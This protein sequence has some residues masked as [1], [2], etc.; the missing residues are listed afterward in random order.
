MENLV[1]NFRYALRRL[2]KSPIHTVTVL[3]C[4]TLGIGAN[5][6]IFSVVNSLLLQPLPVE[7]V[8]RLVFALDVR[9]EDDPFEASIFDYLEFQKESEVFSVTGLAQRTSFDLL[10]EGDPIRLEGALV[11]SD[12]FTTLGLRSGQGR[13]FSEGEYQPDGPRVALIG[14]GLWM[15][16]FGGDESALGRSVRLDGGLVTIVGVLPQ[17][18]DLPNTTEIWLPYQ[19]NYE[20]L[21]LS[22]KNAHDYF[23][24]ARL[25]EGQS[26][27]SANASASGVAERLAKAYPD[28]RGGWNTRLITLR[29]QLMGDI[30]GEVRPMLRV[31]LF[32]VSFLLLIACANVASLLLVRSL[33]RSQEIA[34]RLALGATRRD[35]VAQMLTESVFLSLLG[36]ALGLLLAYL[37]T[38]LLMSLNPISAQSLKSFFYQVPL[39]GRVLFYNLLISLVTGVLFGLAPALRAGRRDLVLELKEGAKGSGSS[40]KGRRWLD[41]LVVAEIAVAA[42]LLVGAGL[43]VGSFQQ[44]QSV[45]LGFEPTN[46][47]AVDL[48]LTQEKY[49]D[50]ETR[51]AFVRRLTEEVAPLPGVLSVGVTTNTP[52]A[53]VPWDASYTVEGA[54]PPEENQAPSSS[55]RVVTPGY[56]ETMGMRLVRGRLLGEQDRADSVSAMVVTEAFAREAFGSTQEAIGKRVRLGS[57]PVPDFEPFEVVG[58]L[59]DV[60]E[61]RFN[62]RLDRPAWY[63]SYY[64]FASSLPVSLVVRT[65]GDPDRLV[66]TIRQAVQAL[67]PT[68]PI[69]HIGTMNEA[70]SRLL[71]PPR[72][73][74]ILVGLFATLGLL[75]AAIGL[76]G[77]M[78]YSVN[79][80]LPELGIRLA[81]GAERRDLMGLVL[82]RGLKLTLVGLGIGLLASLVLSRWLSSLLFEIGTTDV[83]TFVGI[84]LVLL[85]TA[86]LATFLPARRSTRIDPVRVLRVE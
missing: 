80:R 48:Y 5:T 28:L 23:L 21:S 55:H 64:Q 2:I 50:P 63:I 76:Y 56:L 32:V 22:A 83:K 9:E 37:L 6:A 85:A 40:R 72:F 39:D 29:Q 45:D 13:L 33:E 73:A 86:L 1:S 81:M 11:S 41:A 31:V 61:D 26:F 69:A 25:R 36:G 78:T 44:M 49:Q 57:P 60:K 67:D 53:Q 58:V 38:P 34:L 66:P 17:G 14:H 79:Q 30:L 71:N 54:P 35:L 46:V 10:G 77:V 18:F 3:A 65:S 51:N 7:D 16:Q 82:G 62:F 43:M 19:V 52:L 15:R 8:D 12:Y 24:I 75:L 20:A 47:I 68:Q 70:V 74:A 4:L 84:S 59:R 42:A 27:D